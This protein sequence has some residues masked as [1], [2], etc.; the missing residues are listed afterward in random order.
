[1]PLV[2][3]NDGLPSLLQWMLREAIAGVPDLVF[4]LWVNDLEPDQDTVLADLTIA[5]FGG[6]QEQTLTRAGWTSPV[7]DAGQAVSTWG[8]VPTEWTVTQGPEEIFGWAAYNPDTLQLVIVERFDVSR[9]PGVGEKIAVL[10][11]VTLGTFVP[12]P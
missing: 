11:R 3:P 5:S 1:M 12:C 9:T 6:F 2:L 4:T 10:P 8:T 7:I